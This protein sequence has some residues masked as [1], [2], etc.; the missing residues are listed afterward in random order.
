ML[1]RGGSLESRK[2]EQ[3]KKYENVNKILSIVIIK[4]HV[5]QHLLKLNYTESTS[6]HLFQE[7]FTCHI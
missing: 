5:A 6:E 2:T 1:L 4:K 7:L 3:H